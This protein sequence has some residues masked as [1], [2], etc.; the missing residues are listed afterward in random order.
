[1]DDDREM[2]LFIYFLHDFLLPV[3]KRRSSKIPGVNEIPVLSQYNAAVCPPPPTGKQHQR[4]LPPAHHAEL[5]VLL[6]PDRLQRLPSPA[7]ERRAPFFR[8]ISAL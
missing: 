7:G 6:L 2:I 3:R 4:L 5:G 1:M 8:F